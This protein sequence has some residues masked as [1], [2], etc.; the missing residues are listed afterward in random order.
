MRSVNAALSIDHVVIRVLDLERAT[1]DFTR[2][3][4]TVTPGGEHPGLGSRNALVCF[5]EGSYLELIAFETPA[6]PATSSARSRFAF[7]RERGEGVVDLALSPPDLAET[8]ARAKHA[9]LK[10][11]GPVPGSRK[12]PDG[13]QVAWE[14]AFSR[15]DDVPF[16]CADVTAREL[17]VPDGAARKHA[18]GATGIAAIARTSRDVERLRKDLSALAGTPAEADGGFSFGRTRLFAAPAAAGKPGEFVAL[19]IWT[20]RR[21]GGGALDPKLTHGARIEL[22]ALA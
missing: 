17:R 21:G 9:G 15:H 19:A 7:W 22:V 14:C 2:L 10:L 20:E 3:G 11:E 12:R 1:S 6:D 4:F 16:L 8:L 18:C 5:E 13:V